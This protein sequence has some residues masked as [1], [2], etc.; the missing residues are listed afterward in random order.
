MQPEPNA[1]FAGPPRLIFVTGVRRSGTTLL[2][3][4]LT[5]CSGASRTL[6]EVQPLAHLLAAFAWCERNYERMTGD[7]FGGVDDYLA[8]R[9][10]TCRSLVDR[11]WLAAGKPGT[12]VLKNP[13]LSLHLAAL[14]EIWPGCRIVACVRD[15]RDQVASEFDVHERQLAMGEPAAA[16]IDA[17]ALAR[18]WVRYVQPLVDAARRVPERVLLLRYEDLVA[19]S[20]ETMARLAQFVGL[21]LSDYVPGERWR[22][23]PEYL[24]RLAQRPSFSPHYGQPMTRARVGRHAQRLSA[25]DVRQIEEIAHPLMTCLDYPREKGPE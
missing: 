18:T 7:F 11:A 23:E 14:I 9:A 6:N 19:W 13:E 22:V 20:P 21:D 4:I 15:P 12:L 24:E 16:A 17:A 25:A 8:Y 5:A 10:E 2:N 1:S 3:H